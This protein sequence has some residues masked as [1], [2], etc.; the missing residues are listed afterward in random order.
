M[1]RWHTGRIT[2]KVESKGGRFKVNITASLEDGGAPEPGGGGGGGGGGGVG[3]AG[4]KKVVYAEMKGL[5]IEGVRLPS[6]VAHDEVDERTW[7]VA[8]AEGEPSGLE[9]RDS[10]WRME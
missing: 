10:G 8:G 4:S 6:P 9:Y 5:S 1:L 2:E 7:E 3:S